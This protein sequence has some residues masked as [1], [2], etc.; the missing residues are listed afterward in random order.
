MKQAELAAEL[1]VDVGTISRN[2]T[3]E[4]RGW[5]AAP[6]LAAARAHG[7]DDIAARLLELCRQGIPKC[8]WSLLEVNAPQKQYKS[9]IEIPT[10]LVLNEEVA[11]WA[12]QLFKAIASAPPRSIRAIEDLIDAACPANSAA[13]KID[14][15]IEEKVDELFETKKI[16]GSRSKK[17][18]N[19]R[20]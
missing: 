9:T 8:T 17:A 19:S 16:P 13:S 4:P 3:K 6:F 18:G 11:T 2:E 12:L 15:D 7:M 10:H 20:N 14:A 1:E 5:S